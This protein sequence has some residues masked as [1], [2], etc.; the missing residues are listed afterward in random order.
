[1]NGLPND[2]SN[3]VRF[4][5]A[6]RCLVWFVVT[7]FF[8]YA[9]AASLIAAIHVKFR[10]GIQTSVENLR[11]ISQKVVRLLAFGCFFRAEKTATLGILINVSSYDTFNRQL[12]YT[13]DGDVQMLR[14]RHYAIR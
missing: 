7:I 11:V 1:M 5:Y 2:V 10:T 3:C 9:A 8:V 13:L 14:K 6:Y 4:G 12:D